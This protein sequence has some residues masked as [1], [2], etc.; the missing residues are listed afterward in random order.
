MAGHVVVGRI[1]EHRTGH[2]IHVV[3]IDSGWIDVAAAAVVPA[4][5]H[6]S[7]V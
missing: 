1:V 7:L 5:I 2:H 4:L 6:Y 3:G